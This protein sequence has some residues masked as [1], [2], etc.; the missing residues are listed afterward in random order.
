MINYIIFLWVD[1]I[2]CPC[3]E[4]DGGLA[5]ETAEVRHGSTKEQV[6]LLAYSNANDP[7]TFL[8]TVNPSRQSDA[9]IRQ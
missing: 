3:P 8:F 2:T 7:V 9:Y 1:V 6:T 5:E 4:P